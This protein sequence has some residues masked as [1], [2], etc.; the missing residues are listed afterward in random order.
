MYIKSKKNIKPSTR[1]IRASEEPIDDQTPAEGGGEGGGSVN[2]DP[3]ATELVF[4]TEDV[5]ELV[6]EITG[7]D[8]EVV[9]DENEITFTIG[10]TDYTVEAEGGEEVLEASTSVRRRNAIQASRRAANNR[11]PVAASRQ[12]NRT[13]SNKP[14]GRV[15]RRS[16]SGK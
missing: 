13:P 12:V 11:R 5:A 8:V 6:A 14:A 7:E 2:V 9:A 4:E 15:I 10:D 16:P 1:R 3:E